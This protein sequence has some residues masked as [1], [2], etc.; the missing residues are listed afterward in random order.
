MKITQTGN[1]F[2]VETDAGRLHVLN[3][4]ALAWNLKRVYGMKSKDIRVIGDRLMVEG[5][6]KVS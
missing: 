4:N 2:V 1:R 6:V 3:W 5:M